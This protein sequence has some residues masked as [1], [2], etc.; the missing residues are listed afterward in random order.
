MILYTNVQEMTDKEVKNEFHRMR[1]YECRNWRFPASPEA[2]QALEE[3]FVEIKRH[4]ILCDRYSRVER[5]LDNH[6]EVSK[7][8]LDWF[9][10]EG[11]EYRW[12]R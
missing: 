9:F 12:P 2:R 6:E 1:Y 8:D 10:G 5:A 4:N 7:E 11:G 3:R